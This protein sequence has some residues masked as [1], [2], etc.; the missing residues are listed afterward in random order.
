MENILALQQIAPLIAI[1]MIV[2]VSILGIISYL[3]FQQIQRNT[4]LLLKEVKQNIDNLE[5]LV[6]YFYET[7]CSK[8][9]GNSA[10]QEKEEAFLSYVKTDELKEVRKQIQSIIERQSDID[11]KL[12]QKLNEGSSEQCEIYSD[13]SKSK[14]YSETFPPEEKSKY[15]EVSELIVILLKD[16]LS[17][18]GQAT[19]QELVYAMPSQYSLAEIYRSL[20]MM[21]ENKQ[22]DWE[23]KSIHP[24][25]ILKLPE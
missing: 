20:E 21:K 8:G 7:A 5:Y 22:I 3:W 12:N 19:A 6:Q 11:H 1:V 4:E 18:K 13:T 10:A 17:E 16:L 23:D 25:S 9:K 14:I 24:Q 2:I 15:K